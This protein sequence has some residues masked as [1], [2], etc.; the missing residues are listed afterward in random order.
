MTNIIRQ[1]GPHYQFA[2]NF[3]F[4]WFKRYIGGKYIFY[5]TMEELQRQLVIS[6]NELKNLRWIT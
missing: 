4:D 5:H 3:S 2:Y 1:R 6:R